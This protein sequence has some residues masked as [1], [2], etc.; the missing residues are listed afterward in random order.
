[1]QRMFIKLYLYLFDLIII[2]TI[3]IIVTIII[4]TIRALG[5]DRLDP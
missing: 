2:P 4:I 3:K 5:S 1:M